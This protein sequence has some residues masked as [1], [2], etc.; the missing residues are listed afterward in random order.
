MF[1]ATLSSVRSQHDAANIA[2]KFT[3]L[4]RGELTAGLAIVRQVLAT[5]VQSK[6]CDHPDTGG[7]WLG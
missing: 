3:K 2:D 7:A 1:W 6:Q 4:V 5:A